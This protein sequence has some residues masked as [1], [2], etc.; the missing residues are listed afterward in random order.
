M[1]AKRGWPSSQARTLILGVPCKRQMGSLARV[2]RMLDAG[3]AVWL[4]YPKGQ[5]DPRDG[6]VLEAGRARGL[7]DRNVARFNDT[8]TALRFTP[9]TT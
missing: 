7:V 1:K 4:V 9:R 2:K 5:A 8:H 6:D 3:G